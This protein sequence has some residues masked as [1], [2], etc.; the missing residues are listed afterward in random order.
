MTKKTLQKEESEYK[1][2]VNKV[3]LLSAV[4]VKANNDLKETQASINQC[5]SAIQ[6]NDFELDT[7]SESLE[8]VRVPIFCI[9]LYIR[10]REL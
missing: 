3:E 6:Q 2:L 7:I 10:D 1:K 4:M 5:R 8:S 9:H